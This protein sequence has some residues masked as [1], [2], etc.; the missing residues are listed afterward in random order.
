MKC[1]KDEISLEQLGKH[2]RL[3]EECRKQDDTK[4]QIFHEKVH[5]MEEGNSSKI[6]QKRK[7]DFRKSYENRNLNSNN[8]NRKKKKGSGYHYGK[9]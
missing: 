8:N 2:L 5:V 7:R 6:S 9:P 4:N 1:N 3:E